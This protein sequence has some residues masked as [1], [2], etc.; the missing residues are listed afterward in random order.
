M[1]SQDPVLALGVAPCI[2]FTG[3]SGDHGTFLR[4]AAHRDGGGWLIMKCK[5]PALGL[6]PFTF[7]VLHAVV[8]IPIISTRAGHPND[9]IALSVLI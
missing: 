3:C 7:S 8:V 4:S 5:T 1:E 2:L 9:T 6:R